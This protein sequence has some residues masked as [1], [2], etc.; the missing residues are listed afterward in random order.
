MRK[1]DKINVKG[2]SVTIKELTVA[3]VRHLMMDIIDKENS[4]KDSDKL[5]FVLDQ[6]LFAEAGI[7][8]ILRMTDLT[9]DVVR[10]FTQSEF[11]IV[12]E[13]CKVLNPDFFGMR[14][15]VFGNL[16]SRV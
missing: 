12:I 8:D 9:I 15:R 11:R 2:I 7:S 4:V 1:E 14:K 10:D 5:E 3:E 16:T 6:Y 13:R